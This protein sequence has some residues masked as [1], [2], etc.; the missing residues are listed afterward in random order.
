ME[1]MTG[2]NFELI[3][4]N[5][6]KHTSNLAKVFY[7]KH[8]KRIDWPAY[9]LDRNLIGNIWSIMKSRLNQII[10]SKISEVI[11]E[12]KEIWEELNQEYID[13]CIESLP[14]RLQECINNKGGWINY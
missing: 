5:D 11:S 13:N 4:D 2:K 12:V 6:S 10:T 1:R 8:C 3:W 9:H 7:K 14:S